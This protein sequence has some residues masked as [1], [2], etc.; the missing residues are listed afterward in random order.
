[1]SEIVATTI[2]D[3]VNSLGER[4]QVTVE[5]GRPFEA[6]EGEWACPVAMRGFYNSLADVR[7]AD[8]L[9]ALC[10]AA[11]LVRQLLTAFLEDGGKI[12]FHNS[13]SKYD[14]DSIFSRVGSGS[15]DGP[16]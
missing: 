11:S 14:L 7:G 1:M 9:Q 16:A 8:S 15:S 6:P 13:E 2:L 4:Q 10:L 5:I 12:F 3:C